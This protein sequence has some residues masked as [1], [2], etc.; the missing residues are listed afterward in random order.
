MVGIAVSPPAKVRQKTLLLVC[1]GTEEFYRD[2]PRAADVL[3][4]RE[5][6]ESLIKDGNIPIVIECDRNVAWLY[7]NDP[8]GRDYPEVNFDS[9]YEGI[10]ME[11]ILRNFRYRIYS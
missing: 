9:D 11:K 2:N 6:M 8:M 1:Q 3:C 10:I 5:E 7:L 4:L